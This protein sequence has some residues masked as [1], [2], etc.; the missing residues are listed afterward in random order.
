MSRPRSCFIRNFSWFQKSFQEWCKENEEYE[1][2]LER[3]I[4][5]N[6]LEDTERYSYR[7]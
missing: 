7:D 1:E 6:W 3:E 4:L 2:E 5:E